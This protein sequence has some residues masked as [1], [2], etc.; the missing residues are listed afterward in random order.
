MKAADEVL[1]RS[2]NLLCCSSW[3]LDAS[4][5]LNHPSL[6]IFSVHHELK[7]HPS[8]FQLQPGPGFLEISVWARTLPKFE[9]SKMQ[10]CLDHN[11]GCGASMKL[12]ARIIIY[13]SDVD[14]WS[15]FE[16]P[17]SLIRKVRFW[18]FA[19]NDTITQNL[20][21]VRKID[22]WGLQRTWI[23]QLSQCFLFVLTWSCIPA[24]FQIKIGPGLP[25]ISVW[26]SSLQKFVPV[27]NANCSGP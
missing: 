17:E 6:S 16:V 19:R 27:K 5:G 2:V 3:V 4:K 20:H 23:A 18:Q 13:H 12:S 1:V 26:S 11:F 22:V 8:E 24:K 15:G 25:E 14:H 10:T 9:P 21:L 7:L